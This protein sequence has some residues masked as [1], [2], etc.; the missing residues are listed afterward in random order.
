MLFVFESL[1]W[2]KAL[3]LSSCS[4]RTLC[5]SNTMSDV[6]W[7]LLLDWMYCSTEYMAPAIALVFNWFRWRKRTRKKATSNR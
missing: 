7:K 6:E 5:V 3:Y 1:F 4:T 2:L